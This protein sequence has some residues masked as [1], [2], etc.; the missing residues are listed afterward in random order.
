MTKHTRGI[1]SSDFCLAS[2]P[3]SHAT[4]MDGTSGVWASIEKIFLELVT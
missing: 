3:S 2:Q 1:S 4:S